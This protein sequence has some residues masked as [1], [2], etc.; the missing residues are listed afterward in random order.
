MGV[1]RLAVWSRDVILPRLCNC[2]DMRGLGVM[3]LYYDV[4]FIKDCLNNSVGVSDTFGGD[5][6]LDVMFAISP[7]MIA[8]YGLMA[9]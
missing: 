8:Q 1:R 2:G 3:G 6:S 7:Q 5:I 4:K 9:L